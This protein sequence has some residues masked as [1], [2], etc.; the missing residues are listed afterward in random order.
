M[1]NL[2][3]RTIQEITFDDVDTAARENADQYETMFKK[4]A[5]AAFIE[6][7]IWAQRMSKEGRL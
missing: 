5:K 7:A 6:G 4:A 3:Y 1:N 2:N